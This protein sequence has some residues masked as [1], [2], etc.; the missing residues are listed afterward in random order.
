M[1]APRVLK[2]ILN[3]YPAL[4]VPIQHLTD[5]VDAVLAHDVGNAQIMVHDFVD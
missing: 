4:H 5:Q 1:S 3:A 2:D